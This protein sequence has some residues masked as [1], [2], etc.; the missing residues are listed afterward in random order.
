[1]VV[2]ISFFSVIGSSGGMDGL[3]ENGTGRQ[4]LNF[5]INLKC[6]TSIFF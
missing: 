2:D 5:Q 3:W 4:I 6:V 1:M